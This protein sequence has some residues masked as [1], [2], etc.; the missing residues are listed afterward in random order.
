[1][2]TCQGTHAVVAICLAVVGV[3]KVN[4]QNFVFAPRFSFALQIQL[5][6]HM[7]RMDQPFP[8]SV[9]YPP[10]QPYGYPPPPP[11]QP[12]GYPPPPPPQAQYP[13]AGYPPPAAAY[14]P[15]AG[16]PR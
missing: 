1:M 6:Q 3:E 13:P 7:S 15:P 11:Q 12:Y 9:G 2:V 10:Q 14:P 8:P 5:H 16:Y 4:A